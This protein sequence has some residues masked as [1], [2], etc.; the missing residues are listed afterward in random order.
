M[1][2]ASLNPRRTVAAIEFEQSV[3]SPVEDIANLLR[4]MSNPA[5]PG[6]DFAILSSI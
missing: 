1:L 5:I 6:P 4:Q 2:L 3:C